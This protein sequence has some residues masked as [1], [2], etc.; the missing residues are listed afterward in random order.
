MADGINTSTDLFVY[1]E[2]DIG[3]SEKNYQAFLRISYTLPPD[4]VPGFVRYEQNA[5]QQKF[6]PDAHW[7]YHW[8]PASVERRGSST[9]A[10]LLTCTLDSTCLPAS[11][12]NGGELRPISLPPLPGA[13][14]NA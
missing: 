13:L 6:M 7:E 5:R 14:R 3:V 4:E 9:I 10:Y 12:A 1:T 2:D 8:D 11:A